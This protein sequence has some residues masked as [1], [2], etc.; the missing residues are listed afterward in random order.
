MGEAQTETG[1][2][3]IEVGPYDDGSG[4]DCPFTYAVESMSVRPEGCRYPLNEDGDCG[5]EDGHDIIPDHCPL[6]RA[7]TVI[8]LRK[9]CNGG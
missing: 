3:V 6:R 4:M 1:P 9:E 5:L 2:D 8:R 7:K